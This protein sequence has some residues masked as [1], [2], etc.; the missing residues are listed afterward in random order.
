MAANPRF[1]AYVDEELNEHFADESFRKICMSLVWLKEEEEG[2]PT[3]FYI[4][5][6]LRLSADELATNRERYE[7]TRPTLDNSITEATIQER[8]TMAA[9]AGPLK[10]E[11]EI[12]RE[13][14]GEANS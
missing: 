14:S 10:G 4:P 11:K 2:E 6:F 7:R 12:D 5:W 8:T 3:G 1:T 9:G 13:Y